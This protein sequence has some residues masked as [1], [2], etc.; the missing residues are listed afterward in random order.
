MYMRVIAIRLNQYDRT[1]V[2]GFEPSFEVKEE[3]ML[4]H[5]SRGVNAKKLK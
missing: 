1:R 2:K 5:N 3:W 4:M